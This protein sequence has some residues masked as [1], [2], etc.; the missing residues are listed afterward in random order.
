MLCLYSGFDSSQRSGR[1]VEGDGKVFESIM[2]E[3]NVM[4][5]G[6]WIDVSGYILGTGVCV[7]LRSEESPSACSGAT[8]LVP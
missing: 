3:F 4:L 7:R 2:S 1:K 8:R 5:I 6:V